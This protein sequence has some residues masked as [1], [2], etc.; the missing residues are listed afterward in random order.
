MGSWQKGMGSAC[1]L[2]W[3]AAYTVEVDALVRGYESLEKGAANK[4]VGTVK[5][6]GLA[7]V[8]EV[9][10]QNDTAGT[11]RARVVHGAVGPTGEAVSGWFTLSKGDGTAFD[12]K[13]FAEQCPAGFE[14]AN[15]SEY[16]VTAKSVLA[17]LGEGT[18]SAFAGNFVVGD[19]V[20]VREEKRLPNGNL[21][22]H[23]VA[24][25]DCWFTAEKDADGDGSIDILAQKIGPANP[26]GPRAQ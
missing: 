12:G 15:L 16:Q 1:P 4:T 19:V 8:S 7:F 20:I 18:D 5:K 24:P 13:V 26:E 21:R 10:N 25:K 17:R 11:M 23:A 14:K 3:S 9:R 2:K 6:G 22:V